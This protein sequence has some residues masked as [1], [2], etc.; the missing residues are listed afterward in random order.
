[1]I[2]IRD[3]VFETNSSSMHAIVIARNSYRCRRAKP[4]R[5][6]MDMN[7]D[8]SN[9]RLIERASA[10][11]KAAYCF[12]L[13]AG[14]I[15]SRMIE[16]KYDKKWKDG[17]Y[18]YH[19]LSNKALEHNKRLGDIFTCWLADFKAFALERY[20]IE[21]VPMNYVIG[22]WSIKSAEYGDTGCYGH[23]TFVGIVLK[24]VFR[25]LDDCIDEKESSW[26]YY[27][28]HF[29]TMYMLDM[30]DFIANPKSAIIQG[31][32]EMSDYRKRQQGKLV[33]KYVI[34]NKGICTVDWP[35]GG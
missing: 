2:T 9:R 24:H 19:K 17:K 25:M 13:I 12:H 35:A 11:E 34:L 5:V 33:E 23:D 14:H 20:N 22:K 8:F 32:D 29:S 7:V 30:L 28:G 1:M 18:R 6:T 31:S 10:D 26:L 15:N 4:V 27:D 3:S 16:P 21:L